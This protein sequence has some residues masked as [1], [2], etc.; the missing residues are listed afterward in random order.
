MP[1]SLAQVV[2]QAGQ[3]VTRRVLVADATYLKKISL[4]KYTVDFVAW[5][6]SWNSLRVNS[7]SCQFVRKEPSQGIS[8]DLLKYTWIVRYFPLQPFAMTQNI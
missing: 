2:S 1:R 7:S 4:I 8:L 6:V 3:L 5:L